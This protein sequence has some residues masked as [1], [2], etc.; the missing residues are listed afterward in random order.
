MFYVP[1]HQSV[2]FVWILYL[3]NTWLFSFKLMGSWKLTSLAARSAAPNE[4]DLTGLSMVNSS[5]DP[6]IPEKKP[7]F[8]KGQLFQTDPTQTIGRPPSTSK[9]S[10]EHFGKTAQTCFANSYPAS[11]NICWQSW[12]F[13]FVA[14]VVHP[15]WRKL[16]SIVTKDGKPAP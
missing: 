12:S 1:Q 4:A 13:S 8:N 7:F 15:S 5:S 14:T 16:T 6:P 11:V 9:S 3:T 2:P 10:F